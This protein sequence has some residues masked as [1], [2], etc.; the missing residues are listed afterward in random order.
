MS[1]K[2]IQIL[3]HSPSWK[4]ANLE[5]DIFDGWHVRT[6]KA[7]QQLGI[8]NCKIEC[9]LPERTYSQEWQT[10]KDGIT[11]RVFPSFAFNYGREISW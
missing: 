5:D 4:S 11:Y 6:A 3:H 8:K 9:W 7:I 1:L 10:E 2:I